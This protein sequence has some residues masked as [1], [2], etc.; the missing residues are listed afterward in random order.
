MSRAA[1]ILEGAAKEFLLKLPENRIR[2]ALGRMGLTLKGIS[3]YT[4]EGKPAWDDYRFYSDHLLGTVTVYHQGSRHNIRLYGE[5]ASIADESSTDIDWLLRALDYAVRFVLPKVNNHG[6]KEAAAQAKDLMYRFRRANPPPPMGVSEG[7]AKDFFD[8]LRGDIAISHLSDYQDHWR[9]ESST[10]QNPFEGPLVN[11]AEEQ[12]PLFDPPVSFAPGTAKKF[13]AGLHKGYRKGEEISSGRVFRRLVGRHARNK[14]VYLWSMPSD[15]QT[16][17]RLGIP[18]RESRIVVVLLI[19]TGYGSPDQEW[20][21][22]QDWS[23]FDILKWSVRNWRNLQGS[24]LFINGVPAGK[25]SY[26]NPKLH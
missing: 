2:A 14:G 19:N 15:E 10:T 22:M 11:E 25:V 5:T 18:W 4:D 24:D 21:I 16:A 20:P 8:K 17:N 7:R 23:C 12:L 26:S 3:R 1:A 9:Y 13:L 6:K